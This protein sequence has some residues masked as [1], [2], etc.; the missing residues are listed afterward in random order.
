M[1]TLFFIQHDANKDKGY[2]EIWTNKRHPII[3]PSHKSQNASVPSPTMQ[4]F[5]IEMCTCYKDGALWDIC[6]MHCGVCEMGL[7]TLIGKRSIGN[8]LE[9]I[10]K[11]KLWNSPQ[12]GM[13]KLELLT[14]ILTFIVKNFTQYLYYILGNACFSIETKTKNNHH[15]E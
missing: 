14:I 2:V 5:V 13:Y 6:L 8:L 9:N 12:P 4:H 10:D 7:F 1:L 11:S 3:D 15:I